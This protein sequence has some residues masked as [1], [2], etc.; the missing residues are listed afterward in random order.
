MRDV[1]LSVNFLIVVMNFK[2]LYSY[3]KIVFKYPK[4]ISD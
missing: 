3:Q 1:S 2:K 4:N